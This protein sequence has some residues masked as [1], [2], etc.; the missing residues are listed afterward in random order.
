MQL[1]RFFYLILS[2]Y[3]VNTLYTLITIKILNLN[4]LIYSIIVVEKMAALS[5]QKVSRF[6]ILVL[7]ILYGKDR[8]TDVCD[9]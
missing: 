9:Y 7:I 6:L 8:E 3:T 5:N 4:L 1:R 2:K